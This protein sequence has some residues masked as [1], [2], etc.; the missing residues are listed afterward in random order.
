MHPEFLAGLLNYI[1][2]DEGVLAVVKD[3]RPSAEQI[4]DAQAALNPSVDW[5]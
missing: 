5:I 3:S 2:V 4:V 1:I